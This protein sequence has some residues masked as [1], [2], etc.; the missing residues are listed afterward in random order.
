MVLVVLKTIKVAL[1]VNFVLGLFFSVEAILYSFDSGGS[2]SAGIMM[3]M[4]LAF[5]IICM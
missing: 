3:G 5:F 1:L 4:G 2:V